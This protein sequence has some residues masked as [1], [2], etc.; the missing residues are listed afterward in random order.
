MRLEPRNEAKGDQL[1]LWGEPAGNE[2]K[3]DQVHLWEEPGSTIKREQLCMQGEPEN[4]ARFPKNKTHTI[5]AN[6]ALR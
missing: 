3:Q 4:E 5:P 1:R 2:D 6:Y